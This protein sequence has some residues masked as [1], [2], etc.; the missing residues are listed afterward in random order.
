M[1]NEFVIKN[2]FHSKG[3]SQVT[4]SLNVSGSI[5]GSLFGSASYAFTASY[6]NPTFISASAAAS[7]FGAGGGSGAGFPYTGNAVIT[8]S[9]L[10]SQSG[11]FVT[12]TFSTNQDAI[13]NSIDIGLGLGSSNTN[14][15]LGTDALDNTIPGTVGGYDIGRYNTA[16]GYQALQNNR[17]GSFNTAIGYNALNTLGSG[18]FDKVTNYTLLDATNNT[19]IG[20]F[21]GFR[22]ESGS[23]NIA[24]G[25]NAMYN[26]KNAASNVAIGYNSMLYY[27]SGS[28]FSLVDISRKNIAIGENS[29]RGSSTLQN[30]SENNIAI[31]SSALLNCTT[32]R[33]NVGIG[34]N[35]LSGN[36]LTAEGNIAIGLQAMQVATTGY[37]NIALGVNALN[38]LTTGYQNTAIGGNTLKRILVERNHVAIG[39]NAME[40]A[41]SSAGDTNYSNVSIGVEAGRYMTGS[42]NV[43]L[44][45]QAMYQ[46]SASSG[47]ALSVAIGYQALYGAGGGMNG[48][49][50]MAIGYR[51]MYG[52]RNISQTQAFGYSALENATTGQ[53]NIAIGNTAM[54]NTVQANNS[55][56]V[57]RGAL[58]QGKRIDQIVAVGEL[59]AEN[60]SNFDDSTQKVLSSVAIGYKALQGQPTTT[61]SG[62]GNTAIGD[63]SSQFSATATGN[64][65]IGAL[66]LAKNESGSYNV[67][68][69]YRSLFW[70]G[71]VSESVSIGSNTMHKSSGSSN[72]AIGAYALYASNNAGGGA[73][74]LQKNNTAIGYGSGRYL[75]TG[76]GNVF[77]GYNAGPTSIGG[78]ASNTISNRLYIANAAGNPLIG[79]D[80][81]AKTVTISGSLYISGSIIPNAGATLTSSFELGSPTAAWNRIWVRSSSIHFVDDSGNELAKISANPAGAIEMPNIYT[82]GTFTAQTFVTQSTTYI[83]EQYH[84]TGSNIFGS[85]SLDT[86][87]FTGSVY[88]SGSL[89]Q[90]TGNVSIRNTT[91]NGN[92]IV[93]ESVLLTGLESSSHPYLVS[94]D[95]ATGQLYYTASS[96]FTPINPDLSNFALV[97]GSNTFAGNQTITDIGGALAIQ[98]TDVTRKLY[99]AGGVS[100]IDW[101]N[102]SL[103]DSADNPSIDYTTRQLRDQYSTPVLEYS[104][105]QVKMQAAVIMT[106]LSQD[107]ADSVITIDTATGQLYITS[108][109]AF[110]ANIGDVTTYLGPLNDFSA[111]VL[112][113]TSSIQTQVNNLTIATSSYVLNSVTSSMSV[114]SSSYA[115]TASYA[116]NVPTVDTSAL[117]GTAS[118]NS[119]TSS[120]QNQVDNLVVATSSYVVNSITSSMLAPYTLLSVTSSMTVLSASYSSTASY[121]NGS[122]T[123][124]S[125]AVTASYISPNFIS[126]SVA[127]S[128]FSSATDISGLN[129]F[130]GS[131]QTQVDNLTSATSSYVTN[132]VTA[133]MLNPYVLTASTSSMSV[134]S[135][136]FANT[137]SFVNRLVQ[138]IIVTGSVN[139]S[140]S[141]ISRAVSASFTG[142]LTGHVTSS[143]IDTAQYKLKNSSGIT[144]VNWNNGTIGFPDLG[145]YDINW[146]SGYLYDS[147]VISVNWKSKRLSDSFGTSIDWGTRTLKDVSEVTSVDYGNRTLNNST[148]GTMLNFGSPNKLTGYGAI[149]TIL[150][151]AFLQVTE[152]TASINFYAGERYN[153]GFDYPNAE[154]Y[155]E[156]IYLDYSTNQWTNIDQTTNSCTRYIGID[157]PN[158]EGVLTEGYIVMTD[159]ADPF[160][161]SIPTIENPLIGM[162]V[163]IKKDATGLFDDSY[164]CNIPNNGYV[165]VIGHVMYRA[166]GSGFETKYMIKFKPSNDWYEI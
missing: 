155:G 28:S 139:I 16:I 66:S 78:E 145:L 15:R 22:L 43:A 58:K 80:F 37:T 146:Q 149:T 161:A 53:G 98:I 124:A 137:A 49:Y 138:N 83:V 143:T 81:S 71:L 4:G 91:V 32:G 118:F 104:D 57:G 141:I 94:I 103:R 70:P 59:A 19:A 86:H 107:I 156:L 65:T 74:R 55:V 144:T 13:V 67:A 76:D 11:L 9:L 27:A 109:T 36:P 110:V 102:R 153:A 157:L 125:Y 142:S 12:G 131:I 82:S 26:N 165:R 25:T 72:V 147:S 50:N 51:A 14:L 56:V 122:V 54:Q 105:N 158:K 52:A 29:L 152:D 87:Q 154:N 112:A 39:I 97:S 18:S 119:F 35:V 159:A 92:L 164:T 115:L 34:T 128:G 166:V 23:R 127:A 6:I 31:G 108:S 106:G 132:S 99:D 163:Y 150:G 135:S 63:N 148:G 7:G 3:D 121:Y 60:Q 41:S 136:S 90:N 162:P 77:I 33:Y 21:A 114:L 85:S 84:A 130:T 38:N 75:G 101:S 116:L 47:A 62:T 100:S 113:F 93:T 40:F 69:G 126:A 96:A 111:S 44:G 140:G 120:I 61:N 8:G 10:V 24:I 42:R 17:S 5:T 160:D 64:T 1:A 73:I 68:I 45:Y 46:S 134:L 89:E 151:P 2:G 129:T 88:I 133:S 48:T 117:V 30:T 79:G 95:T 20:Y 123:S